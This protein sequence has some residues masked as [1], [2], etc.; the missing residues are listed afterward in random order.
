MT[1]RAALPQEAATIT[2][3]YSWQIVLDVL[4]DGERPQDWE[5]WE[6]RMHVWT[7]EVSFK[8]TPGDGVSFEPIEDLEGETFPRILPVITMT[9]QQ[10]E[11]LR[12]A[13]PAHYVIDFK[14]PGGERDDYF[15]G[16]LSRVFAPPSGMLQ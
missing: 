6:I 12:G 2:P 4:F 13:K 9:A 11:V 8:L 1:Y 15:A 7:D 10:T 14:A 3:G 16:P 5:M